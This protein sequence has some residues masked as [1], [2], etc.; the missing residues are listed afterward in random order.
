MFKTTYISSQKSNTFCGAVY[1]VCLRKWKRHEDP[2]KRVKRWKKWGY[3]WKKIDFIGNMEGSFSRF[4][5]AFSFS[6]GS[7]W[8][9]PLEFCLLWVLIHVIYQVLFFFRCFWWMGKM[10]PSPTNLSLSLQVKPIIVTMQLPM[11]RV[12]YSF[13]SILLIS[14]PP[15]FLLW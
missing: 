11:N 2:K 13:Q 1:V 8:I 7:Q 6:Y 3:K 12:L 15:K 10:Y 9:C 5:F 14:W 4:A